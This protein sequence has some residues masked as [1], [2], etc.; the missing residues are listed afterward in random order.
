MTESLLENQLD[1]A[2]A[3]RL[4]LLD[5]D[6]LAALRLFSGFYEGNPDLVIDLYGSTLV[7]VN[8]CKEPAQ[9]ADLLEAAQRYARKRFPWITCAIQKTRFTEDFFLKRGR[10]TLGTTPDAL[11]QEDGLR[12]ALDL[13]MNQDASFY[14]DTRNLRAWLMANSRGL[15][16]INTFAYTG[17]LGVAAL[18]GGA[19]KVVQVDRSAKYMALAR[20]SAGLNRLDLGKMKLRA[21]DFF[22]EVGKLK[23]ESEVFDIALLD[24]PFFSVTGNGTV[25]MLGESSRLINKLRPLVRDGGRL[26]AINN[27]L[28]LSGKDYMDSLLELCTGGY[29]E[30]EELLPVPADICGYPETIVSAAPVDPE[31]FNHSTKIAILRVKRKAPSVTGEVSG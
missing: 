21:A 14:L 25:D 20:Q 12:Y 17:S 28:F 1:K 26:I 16:V 8:F 7:L 10:I 9:A 2:F 3:A 11:I 13:R 31:P 22:S 5:A 15:S 23:H 19:S 29:L 18:A 27:A 30:I 24:P 6:H 4:P